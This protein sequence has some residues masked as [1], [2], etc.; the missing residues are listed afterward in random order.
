M[1]PNPKTRQKRF[2]LVKLEERIVPAHLG[3]VLVP[4]TA[5]GIDVAQEQQPHIK[6]QAPTNCRPDEACSINNACFAGAHP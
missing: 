6:F 3:T 5:P 2:R 4:T 1:E